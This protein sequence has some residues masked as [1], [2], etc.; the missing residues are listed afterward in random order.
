M[1]YTKILKM[2]TDNNLKLEKKINIAKEIL[3]TKNK[4]NRDELTEILGL[5]N[6]FKLFFCKNNKKFLKLF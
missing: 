2:L 6:K 4:K 5:N 1:I 3:G